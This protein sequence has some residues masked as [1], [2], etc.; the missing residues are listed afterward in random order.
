M[1]TPIIIGILWR[2]MYNFDFG[3]INF[4]IEK[5]GLEKVAFLNDIPRA[6]FYLSIVDVWQWTPLVILLIYGNLQALPKDL[7]EAASIDG[8]SNVMTFRKITFPFMSQT[9]IVVMLIRMMDAIREYDKV[10]TMTNGGPGTATETVSFYIYR[11]AFIFFN[12]PKAAAA[13]IMLLIVTI[14][15]SNIFINRMRKNEY[16]N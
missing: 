13:S 6:I 5:I 11:Q 1:L 16:K 9:V 3:M 15:I 8:A 7:L 14:I 12:M 10:F 4:F 2:F